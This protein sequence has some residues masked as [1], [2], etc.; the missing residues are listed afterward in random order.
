MPRIIR[1][2]V[3]VIIKLWC[4]EVVG[5]PISVIEFQEMESNMII[6]T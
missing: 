5:I 4:L 6:G 2:I 3:A 1:V